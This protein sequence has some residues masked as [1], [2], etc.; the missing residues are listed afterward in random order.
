MAREY[1]SIDACC[2]NCTSYISEKQLQVECN[3]DELVVVDGEGMCD[4]DD[5]PSC[6]CEVYADDSCNFYE[7]AEEE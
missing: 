1:S 3:D 7:A 6:Q 4:N 2:S 5:S